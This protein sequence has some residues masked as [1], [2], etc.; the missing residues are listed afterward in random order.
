M[1]SLYVLVPIRWLHILAATLAV[2]VPIYVRFVL[3]PAMQGLDDAART[4]LREA[5]AKRWRIIVYICIV[6]FL[7]TGFYNYLVVQRW[8]HIVDESMKKRYHMLLGIKILLAFAAFFISSAVA[9]RSAKLANFRTN[10]KMW[11]TVLILIGL[12]IIGLSA[13]LRYL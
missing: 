1:D 9:G 7:A 10:A 2:G 4:T 11:V 3:M 13:G 5:S 8:Q 6:I 12:T